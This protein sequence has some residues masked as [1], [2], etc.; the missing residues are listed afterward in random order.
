MLVLENAELVLVSDLHITSPSDDRASILVRLIDSCA[1]AGVKNFVMLG[2]VFE[3]CF[4]AQ[5]F[6]RQQFRVIGEAL[7][8]LSRTGTRVIYFEGNHEF[9]LQRLAWPGV[10]IVSEGSRN[11]R[12]ES[13][14]PIKLSHG[15][16]I[17]ASPSYLRFRNFVKSPWTRAF[18]RL[19]PP[20]IL[21][22]YAL[23][24]AK[25]S[26]SHDEYRHLDHRALISTMDTWIGACRYGIIGHFHTPYFEKIS[27]RDAHLLSVSCWD[28]I[29]F[30][31]IKSGDIFRGFYRNQ[32]WEISPAQ[33]TNYAG[34]PR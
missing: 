25:V 33:R 27:D 26:R 4:P 5:R 6:H 8:R 20:F 9:D 15:D 13:I 2:D 21:N 17:Y 1:R 29:N 12:I 10:E 11:L 16:L 18:A 34:D 23:W 3:F 19:I 28:E 32:A 24:Q 22:S 30:L 14:G 31:A 7:T